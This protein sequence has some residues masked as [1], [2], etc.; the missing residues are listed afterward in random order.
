MTCFE[1][2]KIEVITS[3][4]GLQKIIKEPAHLIGNTSWYLNLIFTPQ[5][6][7]IKEPG[8]LASTKKKVTL[9]NSLQWWRN[10]K[11]TLRKNATRNSL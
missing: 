6:N 9:Y 5:R 3:H 1:G 11:K 2:S 4:F 7:S 10:L 8:V